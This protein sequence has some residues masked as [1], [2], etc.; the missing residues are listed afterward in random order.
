MKLFKP[1][2]RTKEGI[3]KAKVEVPVK[4]TKI[5]TF[6]D[7]RDGHAYKIVKIGNQI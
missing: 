1:R 2:Q 6:T 5:N 7:P 4:S 3:E